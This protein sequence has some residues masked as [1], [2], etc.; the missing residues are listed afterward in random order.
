MF[1][2][3]CLVARA[4]YTRLKFLVVVL[5]FVVNEIVNSLSLLTIFKLA[6]SMMPS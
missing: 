5:L 2:Q 3:V 4:I 1:K 6:S